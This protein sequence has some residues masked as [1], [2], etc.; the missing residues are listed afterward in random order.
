MRKLLMAFVMML[1]AV[2]AFAQHHHMGMGESSKRLPFYTKIGNRDIYHIYIA[3]TTVNYTGKQRPAMAING[4]I[5]APELQFTEGDTAEIYVHN[6]MMM[7]TSIHWHGLI[8]PNRYD[9]VSYLTTT[10]IMGGQTHLFKFP[11]VQHGT[12][13]YHSHTMTQE[14]SG[15]YG[16]FI[17][18]ERKP[19]PMKEYTLLLSDW[20]DENPEQVQRRLHNATDWYAIRKGSTQDYWQALKSG[21]V[22]TKLTNEWKRMTAMDVSDVYY[23]RFFSNGKPV[24]EAPQFKA[25][26]KVRLRVVNGS[27]STY[28]WLKWAGGK[29]QVVAN[30][31]EDVQ[32]VEVDRMIVGVAE[33]YD[34]VVTIPKDGSYEFLATPEDRTRYTSLWLGPG[35]K[36]PAKKLGRLKYFEG[37]KM[38]ND[39][40]DMHGNMKSMDG[41]V[42]TNQVM[43]MNT[44]MYPEITGEEKQP[45]SKGMA[46]D[47]GGMHHDMPG[48]DMGNSTDIVTLN[49]NMLKST[50]VTTLPTGPTKLLNFELTGNMNRYVWTI[51]N[52]TVSESDKILIKQGE[53]VRIIL[54][55]NTMMR[56]PMHL[57]GHYFRVLNGQGEYS[58]LKNTLDIMPMERD[59]I[60]F[61]ASESGDW[62]FHCHILYHMMSGM[63]R[64]FS[65]ENSPPNPE[66][67]DPVAAMKMINADD[68]KFYAAAKVGLE[69]NGSDGNA[70]LANTRWRFSTMWHLGTSATKG[71]ESETMVGRFFGRMQWLYAYA[72]FDY[73]YK[74]TDD[75]EKNMFGQISNKNNRHT[76]VAGLAYTLPMLFVADL[77]VDGNGKFRFQLGREDIPLTNR[78]RMTLMG[79]T[80]KEYTAGLR[81][82]V[83][84]TF[85]LSSHYDSDMGWGGGL[86]LTY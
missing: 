59:T 36:H 81:Y 7:E 27:S 34:V 29:M 73:H 5:P 60:E 57:H 66:V 85:S 41:M 64:I 14:Q 83:N 68:R 4:S 3:D 1:F 67:P 82:V 77:R 12:Y 86:T 28:F 61:R 44:V 23:D 11:L 53:N 74:R 21:H 6:L 38:M 42:M 16:S 75:V 39:M 19:E 10:P 45:A 20:T 40:M 47:H 63:G 58:P 15:L 70:S 2:V 84:K 78:L 25:G 54:Y 31:G 35:Q 65:Y 62:F 79:N 72:G 24:A 71:F 13:W 8:L 30:D 49:Y 76:V 18:H 37:M 69:S 9:G 46:E 17:I 26:E 32:P 50:H 22:K 52:K 80:D 56:H 55:N 51:N 48:M 43:D 33:T